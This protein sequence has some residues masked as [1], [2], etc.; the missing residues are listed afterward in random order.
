MSVFMSRKPRD[1]NIHPHSQ[2]HVQY[3]CTD[4]FEIEDFPFQETAANQNT[5][6]TVKK[7]NLS[8][9]LVATNLAESY[10]AKNPKLYKEMCKLIKNGQYENVFKKST[11]TELISRPKPQ[12]RMQ[13]AMLQFKATKR[14][15]PHLTVDMVME[16]LAEYF[17][18]RDLEHLYEAA[19]NEEALEQQK[20]GHIKS[21]PSGGTHP[22]GLRY[23]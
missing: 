13:Q 10:K 16:K 14:P 15:D 1:E 6:P 2:H 19:L 5:K 8:P 23:N 7:K 18:E 9:S 22:F 11:Q 4:E 21:R 20:F 17:T 12:I 3:V